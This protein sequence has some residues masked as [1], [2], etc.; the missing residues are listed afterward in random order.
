MNTTKAILALAAST[1]LTAAV[2]AAGIDM[3]DPWR[4]V[5]REDDIRVDAQLAR[6][7]ITPG[8][9]IAVTYQIQNFTKSSIAIA[10]RL[11]D[12]SYDE[13]ARTI[14]LSIGS[15]VPVGGA[16]PHMV[17]IAPGEKRVLRA[18]AIPSLSA[19]AMRASIGG[20]PRYVQVK[21]TI[22][23]DLTPFVALI[24]NQSHGKQP[25][26]DD[27]FNRWMENSATI[28][29]NAVPIGWAMCDPNPA[30]DASARG[31]RGRGGF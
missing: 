29:L 18:S 19:A 3:D 17:T 24:E 30:M 31:I 22:L 13:D 27:L 5:G 10:D 25:L 11:S 4:S 23:R 20:A 16:M 12:A 6:D 8:S 26:S 2:H 7:S 14:T 1:L 9:A 21:V 28:L 15:E